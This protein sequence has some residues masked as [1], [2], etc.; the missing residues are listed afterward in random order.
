M[1][2]ASAYIRN[3]TSLL[4][5]TYQQ[6]ETILDRRTMQF[7]QR[8][9]SEGMMYGTN[10]YPNTVAL[11]TKV[12]GTL[13]TYI[14][15]KFDDFC[16]VV[17][18]LREECTSASQRAAKAKKEH[19]YCLG[20][21]KQLENEMRQSISTFKDRVVS[22]RA[23]ASKQRENSD[24]LKLAAVVASVIA[25]VDGGLTLAVIGGIA[26]GYVG[27]R[28]SDKAAKADKQALAMLENLAMLHQL[29]ESVEGLV[30]AVSLVASFVTLLESELRE[31]SEV[32]SSAET[33][34][35]HHWKIMTGKAR[36]LVESCRFFI[37]VEPTIRSDL[38]SIKESLD[39]SYVAEWK[40]GF[41]E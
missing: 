15:L 1:Q 2:R 31:L 20:K 3:S 8:L 16:P 37:A 33:F 22:L 13:E 18:E 29:V 40:R 35:S 17:G 30:E 21:L 9:Y 26:T 11:V 10:V 7:R 25:A 6:D 27:G 34:R 14:Y 28:L 32:G 41:I 5:K 19:L 36:D 24:I 4:R 12:K 38:L 39:E 23:S